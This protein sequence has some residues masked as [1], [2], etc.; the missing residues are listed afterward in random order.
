MNNAIF[1]VTE[2]RSCPI[3]NVGEEL[4]VE[5]FCLS[6]P[7]FKPQCLHLSQAIMKVITTR[8]TF[9]GLPKRT[10]PRK[11][12][13]CG[14]CQGLIYFEFKKEKDFATL[15]MKLLIESEARR[16]KQHLDRFFAILRNLDVFEALDDDAL[17][18]LIMLLEM[19]IVPIDRIIL[20]KDEPGSHLFIILD[21]RVAVMDADGSRITELGQGEIFGEMSLLSDEPVTNDVY[22]I[23]D[24]QVAM[25]SLKNLRHVL[26][27][28]PVLQIFL[29]KLLVE[30][31]QAMTLRSGNIT[32]GMS[33][34]LAEIS[35]VDLLQ[36]INSAQKTGTID[37]ALDEGKA[38]I[39]F[40]EGEIVHARLRSLRDKDAIYVILGVKSGRFTYTRGIGPELQELPP[41]GGFIGLIMEGLQR[42]DEDRE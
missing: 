25:L 27:K 28:Y 23:A 34:E 22:T 38:V 21:G 24:T 10:G 31:A 6:V 37:L 9:S 26:K 1:L 19:K 13:D 14:G 4:K 16:R 32:S 5:N 29:F 35:I 20:K 17:I 39:Y 3:Y 12:F 2:E 40:R 15:Q 36:L 41:I 11:R 42:L 7:A 8:A 30:R 18:D 33:G